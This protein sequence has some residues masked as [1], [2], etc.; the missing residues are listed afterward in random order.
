MS[1]PLIEDIVKLPSTAIQDVGESQDL[2]VDRME[3]FIT[4]G[5]RCIEKIV[6]KSY[7]YFKDTNGYFYNT[8]A[9]MVTVK[10]APKC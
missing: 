9:F 6:G 3:N 4:M 1:L 10:H 5:A 8:Y 7:T 2:L